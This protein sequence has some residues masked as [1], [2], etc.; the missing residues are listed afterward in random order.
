MVP[1][2]TDRAQH[3][4]DERP[5]RA[6]GAAAV[7]MAEAARMPAAALG[8]A[9]IGLDIV[10]LARRRRLR[11]R[12]GTLR[13]ILYRILRGASTVT[14]PRTLPV[15]LLRSWRA[16]HSRRR[17]NVGRITRDAGGKGP[18]CPAD[19]ALLCISLTTPIT[20]RIAG[21]V[22]WNSNRPTLSSR[23]ST[24]T[25]TRTAGPMS[26]RVRHCSHTQYGR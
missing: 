13:R 22:R 2:K 21:Q 23:K 3:D 25:V 18:T 16:R 17:R 12:R 5:C 19:E 24:P 14:L 11:A 8:L 20:S 15:P 4:Q 7:A 6:S 1:N 9:C 26:L 10:H